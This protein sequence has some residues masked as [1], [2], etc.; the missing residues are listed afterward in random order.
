[1]LTARADGEIAATVDEGRADNGLLRLL[2]GVKFNAQFS[3]R[4]SSINRFRMATVFK[5][6][7]TERTRLKRYEN[8]KIKKKENKIYHKSTI[9]K[10]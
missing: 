3:V 10:T 2:A 5:M 4:K 7:A 1:M 9:G 6:S 8:E